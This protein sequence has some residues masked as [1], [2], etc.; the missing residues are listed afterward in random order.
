MRFVV[1]APDLCEPTPNIACVAEDLRKT[2]CPVPALVQFLSFCEER[3]AT[4]ALVHCNNQRCGRKNGET[5]HRSSRTRSY[6]REYRGDRSTRHECKYHQP[7]GRVTVPEIDDIG[8]H[9]F[10]SWVESS[11]QLERLSS[12]ESSEHRA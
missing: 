9:P 7:D 3:A 11:C 8:E 2:L 4:T 5:D 1:F 12:W 10:A 6:A